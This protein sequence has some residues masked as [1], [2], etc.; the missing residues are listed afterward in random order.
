[1]K[2]IQKR[3]EPQDFTH[4]KAQASPDWTPTYGA[5]RG[6]EKATVKTALMVEQGYLCCYCE[7]Q[8]DDQDSH[9]EHFRPQHLNAVDPLDFGNMLCSCQKERTA[10]EPLHCGALKGRWFDPALLISPLD[11]N[12]ETRF[13]FT[14]DGR[15]EPHAIPDLAAETTIAKL[16]L[17]LPK[18]RALRASAIAPFID[19]DLS[20]QELEQFVQG[21]LD[22]S[23]SGKLSP[24]WT[25]IKQLLTSNLAP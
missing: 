8:I 4:W 12:C 18:L 19:P 15:I 1:M 23:E 20:D 6:K 9:I 11:P 7:R 21:Y 22:P 24:F 5:L 10:G 2:Y 25:T 3:T 14:A 13:R 17:A 16:G